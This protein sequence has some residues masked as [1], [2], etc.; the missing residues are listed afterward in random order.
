[1]TAYLFYITHTV[2]NCFKKLFRTWVAALIGIILLFGLIGG[3]VG[4]GVGEYV[5]NSS[6]EIAGEEYYEEETV[7]I[8]PEDFENI[9]LPIIEMVGFAVPFI[10]VLSFFYTGDKSGASIFTMSDVNFLFSSPLRP[11]SILTFKSFIQMGAIFL[12]SLYLVAQIPNLIFNLG[13]TVPAAIVIV[14]CFIVCIILGMLTSVCTYTIVASKPSRKKYIVP[15]AFA[16]VLLVAGILF[17]VKTFGNMGWFDALKLT[18]ASPYSRCVPIF[19]WM[20][21]LVRSAV[22]GNYFLCLLMLLAIIAFTVFIFYFVWKIKADFYEDAVIRA[23]DTFEKAQA[24]QTGRQM[25]KKPRKEAKTVTEIGKGWG[26]NAFFFKQLHTRR[27]GS[28]L[29]VFSK[30]A[31]T[32]LLISVSVSAFGKFL[33]ELNDIAIVAFILLVMHFFRNFGSPLDEETHTCFIFTVPVSRYKTV[34]WLLLSGFVSSAIDA[35]PAFLLSTVILGAESTAAII[36]LSVF[37]TFDL[38]SATSGLAVSSLMPSRFPPVINAMLCIYLRMLL[39][40]PGLLLL[41][42]AIVTGNLLLFGL[43]TVLLNIV[44]SIVCYLLGT[45][46]L[47]SE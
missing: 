24:A 44:G 28:I 42:A 10:F 6:D 13:L 34:A 36:W 32:Y 22:K 4:A 8:S 14:F 26:A 19:G 27:R 39:A 38:F 41:I 17:A 12:S 46:F 15:I 40:V 20:A 45:A 31:F 1:M 30:A 21:F 43:L 35:I 5:D 9:A 33:L 25:R 3:V 37:L 11:Q 23:N 29:G 2:V 18:F 16:V 47:K 7:E